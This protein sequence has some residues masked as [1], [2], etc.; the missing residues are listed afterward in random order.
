VADDSGATVLESFDPKSESW[1]TTHIRSDGNE[2]E[3]EK[4][5]P[6]RSKVVGFKTLGKGVEI[7]L[8]SLVYRKRGLWRGVWLC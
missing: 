4:E 7:T 1:D 6:V 8:R 3:K 2:K 5:K